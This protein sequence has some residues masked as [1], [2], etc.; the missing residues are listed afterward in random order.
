MN[1]SIHPSPEVISRLSLSPADLA[2]LD[3]QGFLGPFRMFEPKEAESVLRTCKQYPASML[4][5]LKGGHIVIRKMYETAVKP[6]ILHKVTSILGPDV[7]L[8][9]SQLIEQKPKTKHRWHLDVEHGEWEGITIWLALKNVMKGSGLSII[10]G[11]QHLPVTPQELEKTHG[12][13]LNDDQAVLEAARVYSPDCQ[14]VQLDMSDGEFIIFSGKTWHASENQRDK[15]RSALIYQFTRPDSTVKIARTYDYPRAVW[16]SAKP[17]CILVSGKDRYGY[18]TLISEKR[19][20][21]WQQFIKGMLI[22][23]PVKC[24]RTLS[25]SLNKLNKPHKKP[26]AR[27]ENN[28]PAPLVN[29]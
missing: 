9:G 18:N 10:T 11:T 2:K 6:D 15:L 22:Y 12:L 28:S 8:W 27:G 14:L 21:N 1:A 16:D 17:A 5:W 23:F 24:L 20:G 29:A 19:I 3:T 7:L 4:P 26:L 25:S 13:D